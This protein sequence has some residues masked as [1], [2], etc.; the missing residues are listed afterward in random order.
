MELLMKRLALGL[1]AI[2][3]G[4]VAALA[5]MKEISGF[6][7]PDYDEQNNLKSQLSGDKAL[8]GAGDEIEIINVKIETFKADEV[9][10]T[11][12][13]PHCLY[14][15]ARKTVQSPSR[16]RIERDNMV[17]T[18][19]DYRYDSNGEVF[20]IRKDVK[21]VLTDVAGRNPLGDR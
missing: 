21:V 16:I 10:L 6:K 1:I 15:R 14:N 2:S 17:I 20:E 3:I 7:V 18:G 19:E 13:S 12:T 5:Q 8:I 11:I 9:D 4:I